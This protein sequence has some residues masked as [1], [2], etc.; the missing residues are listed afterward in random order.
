MTHAPMRSSEAQQKQ[1]WLKLNMSKGQGVGR[2]K[3]LT[4]SATKREKSEKD[5]KYNRSRINVGEEF[6]GWTDLKTR[7]GLKIRAE[8]GTLL[9]DS[10]LIT[11]SHI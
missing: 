8:V 4:S 1:K 6:G 9:L 7:F 11:K 5:T 3:G 10:K 2:P